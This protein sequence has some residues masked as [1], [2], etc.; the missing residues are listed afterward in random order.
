MPWS[1]ISTWTRPSGARVHADADVDRLVR[2]LDGVLEQVAEDQPQ[3]AAIARTAARTSAVEPDRTL[4]DAWR[5]RTSADA[6]VEHV[7]RGRPLARRHRHPAALL[8]ARG[9][10]HLPDRL[11]EA[12]E[13][14]LH[15][16]DELAAPLG[17]EGVTTE[18]VEAEA[19]RSQRRLHLVG[20]G[21]EEGA[22]S[23]IEPH[24]LH[25]PDAQPH[26]TDHH[27]H[28]EERPEHEQHPVQRRE[29][30][31]DGRLEVAP[32]QHLPA[33]EPAPA[34]APS[35]RSRR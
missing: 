22:L 4:G 27:Q 12:V 35:G 6:V 23:L 13:V 28:E 3:L 20:D 25:E 26:E 1:A 33:D 16:S 24:F 2:V 9:R 11:V 19:E 5:S 8:G 34:A 7:E 18:R 21:V 29:A 14:L 31:L 15:A 17:G 32:D 10:E 30:L